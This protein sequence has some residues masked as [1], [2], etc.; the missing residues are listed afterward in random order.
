M[1]LT[2]ENTI[3]HSVNGRPLVVRQMGSSHAATRVLIIAGQHGDESLAR[4]AV[5]AL[6]SDTMPPGVQ[7]AAL[8]DANPDGSSRNTRKNA[9]GI[10]LNRDHQRL[11]SPETRAMHAFARS[12]RPHLIVDVHTYPPRRKHLLARN[13]V[14]AN[15]VY[16]D[17]ASNPTALAGMGWARPLDNA[18][19]R[20]VAAVGK[21]GFRCD[22]YTIITKAGRVR[23]ST[24]D[25][26]DARNGLS[27]RCGVPTVLL[28]GREPTRF[29]SVQ[30]ANRTRSALLVAL[31]QV[32]QS[33]VQF[34]AHDD[35]AQP[36]GE[37]NLPIRSRYAKPGAR[38]Q[39]E[40]LDASHCSV[41]RVVLDGPYLPHVEIS[42]FAQPPAAYVLPSTHRALIRLLTR[43]GLTGEPWTHDPGGEA[44]VSVVESF[45]PPVG[46]RRAPRELVTRP[47]LYSG[48][49]DDY[50]LYRVTPETARLLTV[51]LEPHSKY[52]LCRYP[53]LGLAP[54]V[55]FALPV[56]RIHR[57]EHAGAC[58]V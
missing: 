51:F 9:A 27:L 2:H 54:R 29:D 5:A 46:P 36:S 47:L 48:S 50:L 30:A 43:H 32:V 12:W 24:P 35:E 22:R 20:W 10:D 41:R 52:G 37:L 21:R 57:T 34:S 14:H 53:K 55:G 8:V 13:L 15:E 7:V 44:I 56:I 11:T 49:R 25:I 58:S 23:H 17:I 19:T 45:Q 26:I 39:L 38:R 28:E 40:M 1:S 3:G 6:L 16:I 4:K 33:G 18:L 31:R 42:R